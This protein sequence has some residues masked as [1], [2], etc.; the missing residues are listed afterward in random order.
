MAW[1]D[2]FEQ[3]SRDDKPGP[4]ETWFAAKERKEHKVQAQQPP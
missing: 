2:S 4:L 1:G 3:E